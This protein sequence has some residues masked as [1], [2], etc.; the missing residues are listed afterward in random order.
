MATCVLCLASMATI[1]LCS[2]ERVC[3]SWHMPR[4][5]EVEFFC[6]VSLVAC[7]ALLYWIRAQQKNCNFCSDISLLCISGL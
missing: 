7:Q 1:I 2:K 6:C 3:A 5:G 4:F